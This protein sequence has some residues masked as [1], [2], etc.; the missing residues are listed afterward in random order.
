MCEL[1]RR[2]WTLEFA[3]VAVTTDQQDET[4]NMETGLMKR[5]CLAKQHLRLDVFERGELMAVTAVL[6]PQTVAISMRTEGGL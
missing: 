2:V 4:R 6:A 5:S 1:E 3:C